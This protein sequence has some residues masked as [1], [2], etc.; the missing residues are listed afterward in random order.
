[1][2]KTDKTD[3]NEA[4]AEVKEKKVKIKALRDCAR[5]NGE[6]ISAGQVVF[7]TEEEAKILC[8]TKFKGYHPFYGH[9]PQIGPLM[10]SN[11]LE[12]KELVRAQRLG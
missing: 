9:M 6:I 7:V 10:E 4:K 11:P 5:M 8:D 1:M 2:D 12:R 3:K